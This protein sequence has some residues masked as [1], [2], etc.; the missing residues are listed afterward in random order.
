MKGLI[1]NAT[2]ALMPFV[3]LAEAA[4]N[5]CIT[6]DTGTTV[7]PTAP[8]W[9]IL[10]S[11]GAGVVQMTPEGAY[12][13]MY[14]SPEPTA[15]T[16]RALFDWYQSTMAEGERLALRESYETGGFTTIR[17]EW[18]QPDGTPL[19]PI[20]VS[21]LSGPGGQ[22]IVE[23]DFGGTG[24]DDRSLGVLPDERLAH[25]AILEGIDGHP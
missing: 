1:A 3:A 10:S 4:P 13:V 14:D 9:E 22:Y 16:A 17:A 6:L 19:S 2:I 21:F 8:G 25:I 23:S 11:C 15:D 24:P 20:V 18:V 5:D 7:C 12:T